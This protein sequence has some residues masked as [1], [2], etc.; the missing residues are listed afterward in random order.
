MDLCHRAGAL[1]DGQEIYT[2]TRGVSRFPAHYRLGP[3]YAAGRDA[4][5]INWGGVTAAENMVPETETRGRT[6][7]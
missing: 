5:Y 4:R 2:P 7:K 3:M 1:H 6:P